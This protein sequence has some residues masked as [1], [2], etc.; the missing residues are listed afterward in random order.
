MSEMG[1]GRT[2]LKYI[3]DTEVSYG[4]VKFLPEFLKRNYLLQ[5]KKYRDKVKNVAKKNNAFLTSIRC[6]CPDNVVKKWLEERL[7]KKTVS[8]GRWEIYQNQ[9][10]TFEPYTL[11]EKPFEVD[12]SIN[13]YDYRMNFFRKIIETI[14]GAT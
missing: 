14:Q 7:K 10:K 9:K 6:I 2:E 3:I 11:E 13:S 1:I 8:D 12:T 4:N 5:K